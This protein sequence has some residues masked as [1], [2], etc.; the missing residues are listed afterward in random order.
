ML[1]L[2]FSCGPFYSLRVPACRTT[3]S[4]AGHATYLP[5]GF[6]NSFLISTSLDNRPGAK[7]L[8]IRLIQEQNIFRT[9]V[10]DR[11]LRF[12]QLAIVLNVTDEIH[13]HNDGRRD[14]ASQFGRHDLFLLVTYTI[15]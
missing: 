4:F 6:V 8:G 14:F 1:L 15:T 5:S 2:P 7:H 12:Q 9:I 11:L 3:I 13:V 10:T